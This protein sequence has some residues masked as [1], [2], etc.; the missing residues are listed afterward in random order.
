MTADTLQYSATV[1]VAGTTSVHRMRAVSPGTAS[2][3]RPTR[4]AQLSWAGTGGR[5][6]S[7]AA[8][9]DDP[10]PPLSWAPG[11][12]GPAASR[13][14]NKAASTAAR[15]TVLEEF[16]RTNGAIAWEPP[17]SCG[18]RAAVRARPW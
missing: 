2:N 17:W 6:A 11:A 9:A 16:V 7:V 12:A 15:N 5:T 3:W 8:G 14:L 13:P 1:A 18:R 4:S 10:A